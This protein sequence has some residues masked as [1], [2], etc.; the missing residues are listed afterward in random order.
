MGQ[1][2]LSEQD[3]LR[4]ILMGRWIWTGLLPLLV[5]GVV[6]LLVATVAPGGP[7]HGKQQTRLAFE[8]VLGVGAALFLAAFYID[9]HWTN[10]ERIAQRIYTAAGGDR[11]RAA[12]SWAHSARH[13]A[14]LQEQAVLAL[15]TIAASA[16]AMT[17]MGGAIG[18]VAIVTVLMGLTLGHAAQLLLLGLFYQ[19]F[20]LSR[21][22]Y[23]ER[24]ADAA[25][26]GEL[27]P[28]D[29]DGSNRDGHA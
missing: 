17:I 21:H 27:L 7:I 9:G 22:P 24:V 19:L 26:R 18:L 10:A 8:V 20:L 13:R 6:V 16:N 25:L 12:S 29:E 2:P 23:Y 28:A 11:E 15:T 1:A 14:Q 3:G 5:C 4:R